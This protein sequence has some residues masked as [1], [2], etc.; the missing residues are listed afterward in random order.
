MK[1]ISALSAAVIVCLSI[2]QF[3]RAEATNHIVISELQ[4]GSSASA[5][6]EFI[7][8]YNP[9]NQAISV[10]GW[11]LQYRP[12]GAT[13][14][15]TNRTSS[16]LHGSIAANGYY[17]IAATTYLASADAAFSSGMAQSG[18]SVRI[19]DGTGQV[20]D[21]LGWGTAVEFEG[22]PAAAPAAGQSL[23]RQPGEANPSGGNGIDSDNN[24]ADFA[25]RQNPEPQSTVSAIEVPGDP[26]TTPVTNPGSS[27]DT[28]STPASSPSSVLGQPKINELF[29]DPAAPLTDLH[30]EFI[31]LYNPT[32]SP[33]DLTGYVLKTG[34]DFHDTYTIPSGSL[35]VGG[36][37]ALYS[38]QTHL[39]LTNTGG[40]AELLDAS[41]GV[42]D[43]TDVY[44]GSLTGLS[45][46]RF[47][48]DWRWSTA[49]TPGAAN[50]YAAVPNAT[51]ASASSSA[52]T[53]SR[54]AASS[55]SAASKVKAVKATKAPKVA[56]L[57]AD[58]HT[59][60]LASRWLI[61]GLATLTIGYAIYEF[62]YDLQ[63]H[64]T[65]AKRNYRTW[66][67]ARRPPSG[68]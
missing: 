33:I 24:Q 62:R 41:G 58:Q 12:A 1:R 63:N 40:A 19:V 59:A 26:I 44:D 9:T 56:G 27:T 6:Q 29:I 47:G 42:V 65:R 53:S 21:V 39:S 4:T 13:S 3:V 14:S 28:G 45:F 49:L 43:Q 37:I 30:D 68:R 20:I 52:R 15:W 46:S 64:Y 48:D 18:G 35:A 8:L 36:Y 51:L 11:Q 61:I 32:P 5:S 22:S 25:I 60:G 34:A 50:I 66:R 16:G 10:E 55:R 7:E 54:R 38:T 23:E 2:S 17:L 67:E 31:E 57:L